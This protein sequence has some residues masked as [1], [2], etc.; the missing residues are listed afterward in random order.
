MRKFILLFSSLI[1]MLGDLNATPNTNN[2]DIYG[3]S[4]ALQEQ[5]FSLCKEDIQEYV[6]LSQKIKLSMEL[7]EFMIKRHEV[8]QSIIKKVNTL[9]DF[10]VATISTISYPKNQTTYST[11]DLVQKT[12]SNRL[13]KSPTRNEI[14]ISKKSEGLKNLFQVWNNYNKRVLTLI[15]QNKLDM[16]VRSCP[17]IHCAWGFDENEQKNDVPKLKEGAAKYKKQ[18][19]EIIKYSNNDEERGEA[20]FILANTKDYHEIVN[21]MISLTNDHSEVVRNNSMRVLGAITS[22]Y[23]VPNLD[24]HRILLALNYPN[25]T[26]RN[27]ASYVLWDIIRKDKS[28]HPLVIK[29]SGTTL[30]NLLKLKQPNNHDYAYLI[31]KEISQQSYAENDYERWQ[32]WLDLEK[33]KL[34]GPNSNWM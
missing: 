22:K 7:N 15:N 8:E 24:I 34:K 20:I 18:L 17:V 11:L 14:K 3:V 4:P 19:I 10:S 9:G 21:L 30:I 2:F 32:Q 27:K 5:I 29:E 33:N 16:K 1:F 26:D 12:D 6:R 23:D 25:V 31:L 28:T 13:P